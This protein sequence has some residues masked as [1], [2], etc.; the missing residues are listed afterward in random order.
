[1]QCDEWKKYYMSKDKKLCPICLRGVCQRYDGCLTLAQMGLAVIDDA[2]AAKAI[3][4]ANKK[5]NQRRK[6]GGSK[7][8]LAQRAA[9]GERT[10]FT[11]VA[12]A[13]DSRTAVSPRAGAPAS[14]A[15]APAPAGQQGNRWGDIADMESL[16]SESEY[17]G[18]MADLDSSNLA[19]CH[20]MAATASPGS[21]STNA[22]TAASHP[23]ARGSPRRAT[24][25]TKRAPSRH[26]AAPSPAAATLGACR[27]AKMPSST[28]AALVNSALHSSSYPSHAPVAEEDEVCADSGATGMM[29]ED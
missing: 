26:A 14:T 29:L 21:R 28:L 6:S 17:S 13:G 20:P 11:L 8:G 12:A 15:P 22:P 24:P 18:T 5:C 2:D 16:D 10:G 3:V 7:G 27:A 23:S 4:D 19:D 9:L 1:M 25:S